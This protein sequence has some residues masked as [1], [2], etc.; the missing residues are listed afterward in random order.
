MTLKPLQLQPRDYELMYYVRSF[1]YLKSR[2]HI[3]KFFG[4]RR[5]IL[6]RASLL[7]KHKYLYQLP[8]RALHE[9]AIF[10]INN[11]GARLV[12]DRY[13]IPSPKVHW[14][15]KHDRISD[16]W[17]KHELLVAD[18]MTSLIAAA[19][20]NP[21]IRYISQQ[22]IFDQAPA[23]R[24]ERFYTMRS[25]ASRKNDKESIE[26][27]VFFDGIWQELWIR[28]DWIFGIEHVTKPGQPKSYYYFEAGRGSERA[29]TLDPD[30]ASYTKKFL[31]YQAA[32]EKIKGV[33]HRTI[34]EE[35]FGVPLIRPLFLITNAQTRYPGTRR[36]NNCIAL[37]REL[38]GGGSADF[39]FTDR[40]FFDHK[41]PL[42]APLHR[43]DEGETSLLD[44]V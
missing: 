30:I 28:F 16:G 33:K 17:K 31:V 2:D 35:L 11:K 6:R 23:E 4:G 34:N 3:L 8:G 41:N 36:M 26:A 7:A 40:T 32:L 43:G 12:R 20:G 25:N 1:G 18:F 24:R 22:E 39:L 13:D 14:P 44:L 37:H 38:G 21:D 15:D 19:I 42:T 5:R 9:Q 27:R 29:E 10:G